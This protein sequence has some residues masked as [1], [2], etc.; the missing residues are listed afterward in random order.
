MQDLADCFQV[1]I[2]CLDVN[3]IKPGLSVHY[4]KGNVYPRHL[5][6]FSD[7]NNFNDI[8]YMPGVLNF[9]LDEPNTPSSVNCVTK[10]ILPTVVN[11]SV[12]TR[13]TTIPV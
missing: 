4:P 1:T 3:G 2:H 11:T 8:S 5:Y 7:S 9:F 13:I 10:N 6:F 12:R